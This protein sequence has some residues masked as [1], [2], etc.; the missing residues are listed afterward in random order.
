MSDYD[1]KS[2]TYKVLEGYMEKVAYPRVEKIVGEKMEGYTD[3][4]LA[5]NDRLAQ[6]LD[7]ILTEQQAI[8]VNYKRVDQRLDYLES[9]SA[10]VA[11]KLGLAFERMS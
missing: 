4:I 10:Q 9:F 11:Q 6:K 1:E 8:T 5:S 3:K 2:I 7:R